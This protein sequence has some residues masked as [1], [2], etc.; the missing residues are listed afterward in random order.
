[1]TFAISFVTIKSSDQSLGIENKTQTFT[2][3]VM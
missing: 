2:D 1:M 3:R